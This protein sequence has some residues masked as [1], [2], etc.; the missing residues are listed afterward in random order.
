MGEALPYSRG[1]G[2]TAGWR[3]ILVA[4]SRTFS[5]KLPVSPGEKGVPYS[6]LCHPEEW[7]G[8]ALLSHYF[9]QW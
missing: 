1:E 6:A 9:S 7:G 3:C 2:H 5:F 8:A 4:S